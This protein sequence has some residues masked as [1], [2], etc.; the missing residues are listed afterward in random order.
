MIFIK[1]NSNFETTPEAAR[2]PSLTTNFEF[3][4]IRNI[5]GTVTKNIYEVPVQYLPD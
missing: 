5:N 1:L 2:V 3:L 4:R